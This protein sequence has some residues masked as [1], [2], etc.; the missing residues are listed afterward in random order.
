[1][2]TNLEYADSLRKLADF[3][4]ANPEL[5][6]PGTDDTMT[7]FSV[8][9]KSRFIA[10]IRSFGACKKTT[11]ETFYRISKPFGKLTLECVIYRS[12]IC[13]ARK[14]E[15]LVKKLVPVAYEQVA[16]PEPSAWEERE[17]LE[18][19]TE[20]DCPGS[21]LEIPRELMVEDVA[22]VALPAPDE[23]YF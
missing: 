21:L 9:Q 20:W 13:T 6:R 12:Q 3:Y 1:M 16:K 11:D 4:E 10:A 22:P 23:I 19:V 15:K 5:E 2:M 7:I 14:V 8:H 18:T 17:V